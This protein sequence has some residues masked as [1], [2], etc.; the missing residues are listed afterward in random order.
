MEHLLAEIFV[1]GKCRAVHAAPEHEVEART[2][3]KPAEEHGDD[4]VHVLPNLSLAVA[5]KRN[6][7]V[8]AYP[9]RER[10]VP[11]APKVGD[12][13]AAVGGVEVDGEVET[14][15]QGNAYGHVAVAAEVTIYLHGIAIDAQQVLDAGIQGGVVEDAVHEIERDIVADNGFLEQT[16]DN[17]IHS[18][19]KHHAGDADRFADL[20][21]KVAGSHN[22]TC[23]ELGKERHVESILQQV[24]QWLER[25]AVDVDGVA[26]ALER[27]ETD[28]HGQ[29][30]V[31]RLEVV[32]NHLREHAG[33]EIGV[34]EVAEQSEVY[35][36]AERD[37]ALAEL[38]V[39]AVA[40]NGMGYVEVGRGD[41]GK[42]KEVHAAALV[43]EIIGEKRHEEQ[44]RIELALQQHIDKR[45]AKKQQQ[46][47]SAAENH[48]LLWVV[49]EGVDEVG[50]NIAVC[51]H[52][53]FILVS[54]VNRNLRSQ[55]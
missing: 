14:Q 23:H 38:A 22:G 6:V 35:Q 36:Q 42:Q 51:V 25:T 34:F 26:H 46:E 27:E 19:G 50:E 17:E 15:Q 13:G 30:D 53:L 12:A 20:R 7:D 31:P 39:V 28:A 52:L 11:A 8:V 18:L 2:V 5:A 47:R 40:V 29:E 43:V 21:G 54:F 32:A 48:R 44:P 3:P 33:K 1:K 9:G 49:A 45:E 41:H 4:E 10:D 24:G 55:P 37:K 16:D